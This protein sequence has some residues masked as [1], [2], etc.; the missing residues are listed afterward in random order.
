VSP[1]CEGQNCAAVLSAVQIC[2]SRP[3]KIPSPKYLI[4]L[5][6]KERSPLIRNKRRSF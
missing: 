5:P 1:V 6:F 2:P 3:F 4:A